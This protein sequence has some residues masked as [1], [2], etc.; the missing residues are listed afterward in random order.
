MPRIS[1]SNIPEHV[2]AQEAAI[3]DA[4]IELIADRGVNQVRLSDIADAVGLARTSVY[5]YFPT[6][7]SILHRW[8]EAAMTPLIEKSS[9]IAASPG[10]RTE[11]LHD[12]VDVQL[13]FLAIDHNQAMI[14]A[15]READDMSDDVRDQIADR[16]RDLYATLYQI[17]ATRNIDN[18]TAQLRVLL[19]AG[20]LR[21]V[22]EL[23][24]QAAQPAMVRDEVHR[25][26]ELIAG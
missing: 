18:A 21:G 5:R 26:A 16:H 19:I 3:I 1:G 22:G 13:D 4:A 2:A 9:T 15:S 6:K 7:T 11:R 10:E 8:F 17:V 12:W 14:T 25:A 24:A 20:L 23:R